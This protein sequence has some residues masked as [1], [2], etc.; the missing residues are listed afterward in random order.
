[1]VEHAFGRDDA[2]GHRQLE[3]LRRADGDRALAH[4]DVFIGPHG[5]P[6]RQLGGGAEHAAVGVGVLGHDLGG[7]LVLGAHDL[8]LVEFADH[9]AVGQKLA[10]AD[11]DGRSEPALGLDL[12]DRACRLL[13]HLVGAQV[14][15]A[16]G[17]ELERIGLAREVD[18][19]C[20]RCLRLGRGLG[21]VLRTGVLL[22]VEARRC[23]RQVLDLGARPNGRIGHVQ[24][25]E[26]G[27]HG[28]EQAGVLGQ[29]VDRCRHLGRDRTRW[30]A[31]DAHEG[32]GLAAPEQ[33]D[34]PVVLTGAKG[35]LGGGALVDAVEALAVRIAEMNGE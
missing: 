29:H 27:R 33:G 6:R 26:A 35:R 32:A 18:G 12:V 9:V 11:G 3:P 25:P 15:A 21:L 24:D 30:M 17:F 16:P 8:D 14:L 13:E 2:L 34:E 4:L 10:V 1:M 5:D 31:G 19:G 22:V 28:A 7:L 23:Q 20:G